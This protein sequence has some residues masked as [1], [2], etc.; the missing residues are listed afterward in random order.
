MP[1]R[2]SLP[3]RIRK[4]VLAIV[5]DKESPLAPG[6]LPLH[7]ETTSERSPTR[8]AQTW[9]DHPRVVEHAYGLWQTAR[10]SFPIFPRLL[11]QALKNQNPRIQ[12]AAVALGRLGDKSAQSIACHF[13]PS[14][15]IRYLEWN[16][17]EEK[18]E[19]VNFHQSPIIAGRAFICLT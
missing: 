1:S 10:Q 19:G 4:E 16:L 14:N 5:W 7:F 13:Q 12:V 9:G 18:N 17:Q 3:R 8:L 15:R 6:W 2:K 11:L